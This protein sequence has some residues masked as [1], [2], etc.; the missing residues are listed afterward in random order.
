[1]KREKKTILCS[2]RFIAK[3]GLTLAILF[4]ITTGIWHCSKVQPSHIQEDL[5][6]EEVSVT[7]TVVEGVL[8]T[9]DTVGE[10]FP[11]QGYCFVCG[12]VKNPGVYAFSEG[13]RMNELIEL[14]GGFTKDAAAAY[15]N[16][17]MKVSDA[18]KIYVPTKKEAARQDGDKNNLDLQETTLQESRTSAKD[19]VNINTADRDKL[20][21][22]PGIGVSKANSIIAYRN[23]HGAFQKIEELKNV[24]GI[25]ERVFQK[26]EDL[27]S[28]Q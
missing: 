18:E 11:K 6:R 25:K 10:E 13:A 22:L 3:S 19:K 15:L 2:N 21:S 17:A 4:I 14:A 23:D 8:E 16:L 1:M 26:I 7:N 20:T 27:I 12:A 9:T 5:N 24:E 28:V